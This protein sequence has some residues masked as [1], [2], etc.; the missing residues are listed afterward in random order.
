MY[1]YKVNPRFSDDELGNK[2][3][4]YTQ[5]CTTHAKENFKTKLQQMYQMPD[6]SYQSMIY[7]ITN[8]APENFNNFPNCR[9]ATT[10]CHSSTGPQS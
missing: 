1:D 2:F 8:P 3:S 9:K 6:S 4:S 7:Q 5:I 10:Y